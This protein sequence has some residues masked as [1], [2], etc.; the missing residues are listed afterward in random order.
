MA[1]HALGSGRRRA[2]VISADGPHASQR[3]DACVRTFLEA[4]APAPVIASF[5][6]AV[7]YR[8]ARGAVAEHL[9]GGGTPDV[10]LCSSDWSAHGAIDELLS[11]RRRVPEEV[12][13]LGF[14]DLEFAAELQPALTTVAIDG[15][16][17][18]RQIVRFLADRSER[19]RIHEPT[20]DIGFSLIHRETG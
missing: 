18:G 20:V 12:A 2:L 7:S 9:D 1:R 6:R 3:R 5:A 16:A 11:R 17:I 19:R 10:V 4:G 14:G 8:Q 15:D 13:V